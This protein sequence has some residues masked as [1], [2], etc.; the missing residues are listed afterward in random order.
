M[1]SSGLS[2][3]CLTSSFTA[4]LFT[5]GQQSMLLL[6]VLQMARRLV[7]ASFLSQA[8]QFH[9]KERRLC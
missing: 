8:M 4:P 9:L 2:L 1:C 3:G 5:L 6:W 7:E